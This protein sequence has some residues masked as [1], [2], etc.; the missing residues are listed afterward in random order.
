[1]IGHTPVQN[2]PQV[3]AILSSQ[4]T[5]VSPDE[6]D[7][8]VFLEGLVQQT[9]L[10]LGIHAQV[11]DGIRDFLTPLR[12]KDS[13]TF[14]H[15]LHSLR[16]GIY[17]Y[18]ICEA[19]FLDGKIGIMGGL[20][21]DIGKALTDLSTL[22]KTSGW[23]SKDSREMVHHVEDGYRLLRGRFDFTAEVIQW[24]HCFQAN[25]YPKRVHP[26]LHDYSLGTRV[27]IPFYGR[28]LA[29]ADVYDALHRVNDKFG[30]PQAFDEEQIKQ[31]MFDLNLDQ[32]TLL[33]NLYAQGVLGNPLQARMRTTIK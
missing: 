26:P 32:H 3:E 9:M 7:E 5:L 27:M 10:D 13:I 12:T 14:R 24:S 20:L 18:D 6:R 22:G 8:Q 23:T 21:H 1:M 33:S 31:K 4:H 19:C 16:V 17:D 2:L 25:R 28:I 11:Q 15:Y 30:T 29:I